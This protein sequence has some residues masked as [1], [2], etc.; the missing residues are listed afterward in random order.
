MAPIQKK[1]LGYKAVRIVRV[2]ILIFLTTLLASFQLS[3]AFVGQKAPE[4]LSPF[5]INSE[6]KTLASLKGKVVMVE[7]W[8][9]GC[10][11][12]RNVEPQIKKWHHSFSDKGLVIIGVHSP[13]F[14]FEKDI[15]AVKHY[16]KKNA[17]PYPIAIDNTFTIWNHFKNRYWPALYLIDKKGVIRY[18]RIG[19]GGYKKTEEM[20][21]KL[22][23]EK[24]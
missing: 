24:Q 1:H 21:I 16:V 9:F 5:W 22:L 3:H 20:I 15:E 19:E 4:I 23:E 10:Y 12:C 13:E 6:P 11:N 2:F 14:S 7:F 17:V 8:T 18:I